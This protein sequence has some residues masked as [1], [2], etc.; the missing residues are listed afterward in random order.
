MADVVNK[1]TFEPADQQDVT[2]TVFQMLAKLGTPKLPSSQ[3]GADLFEQAQ[4]IARGQAPIKQP[5]LS[6]SH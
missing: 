2:Y 3:L 6:V 4:K 1:T 5:K